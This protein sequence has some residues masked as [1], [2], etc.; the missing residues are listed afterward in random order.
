MRRLF[1]F[2]TTY[3][4][5]RE[6]VPYK[7]QRNTERAEKIK[8]KENSAS[9]FELNLILCVMYN[10]LGWI[11]QTQKTV[12]KISKLSSGR[13]LLSARM[14]LKWVHFTSILYQSFIWQTED[15]FVVQMAKVHTSHQL[16]YA[17]MWQLMYARFIYGTE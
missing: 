2:V 5:I 9:D 3:V 14:N 6:L 10:C 11:E 4:Y 15:I 7:K 16:I 17:S 1:L 13:V 12:H 8:L